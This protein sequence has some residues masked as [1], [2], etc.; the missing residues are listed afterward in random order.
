[1]YLSFFF[2]RFKREISMTFDLFCEL[3]FATIVPCETIWTF[4]YTKKKYALVEKTRCQ[5]MTH[6]HLTQMCAIEKETVPKLG[7]R[8]PED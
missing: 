5:S 8:T 1:M 6:L 4:T 2:C 7:S 3:G